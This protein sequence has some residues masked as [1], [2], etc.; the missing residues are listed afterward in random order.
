MDHRKF[1]NHHPCF[2]YF[3]AHDVA[4]LICL[5]HTDSRVAG[6]GLQGATL[7]STSAS[8]GL[9]TFHVARRSRQ[10]DTPKFNPNVTFFLAT[11]NFKPTT[12]PWLNLPRRV[13]SAYASGTAAI[14]SLHLKCTLRRG[15]IGKKSAKSPNKRQPHQ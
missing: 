2:E 6:S 4:C 11:Q 7:K 15:C 8:T 13:N 14:Q 9:Y 10:N 5:L 12:F 1:H 3:H